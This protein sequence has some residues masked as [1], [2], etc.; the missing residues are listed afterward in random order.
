[1]SNL[2]P[3]HHQTPVCFGKHLYMFLFRP[4]KGNGTFVLDALDHRCEP[5]AFRLYNRPPSTWTMVTMDSFEA[6]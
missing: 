6:P 2:G 4:E 1:M 5:L 3:Q